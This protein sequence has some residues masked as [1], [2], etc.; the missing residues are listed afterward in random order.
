MNP[1]VGSG[2][3]VTVG[4][5]VMLNRYGSTTSPDELFPLLLAEL[6]LCQMRSGNDEYSHITRVQWYLGQGC[7]NVTWLSHRNAVMQGSGVQ[8]F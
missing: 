5:N 8:M 6:L 4:C 2:M 7:Y 1:S 3:Y